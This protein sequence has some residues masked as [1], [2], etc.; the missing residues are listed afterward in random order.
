MLGESKYERR[1]RDAY[2]TE[3]WVTRELL[4][5]VPLRGVVWEP[6]C[7]RGDMADVI[8][9]QYETIATDVLDHG[10]GDQVDFLDGSDWCDDPYRDAVETIVT[11]PP[12]IDAEAF[13]RTALSAMRGFGMVAMLL[14]NEWDSAASR[15]DLFT[16]E[17]FATKLVLTRRPRWDWWETDKPKASPRHNF[18]WFVWD[19]LHHGPPTLRYM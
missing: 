13:V 3:P 17:P 7:G 16:K 18:S 4:N 15:R 2:W 6:A 12:Y 11:N 1:L 5:C 8:K 19:A 10:Y 14:R 9:E